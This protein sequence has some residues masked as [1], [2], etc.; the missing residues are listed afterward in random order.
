MDGVEHRYDPIVLEVIRT[1]VT[2]IVDEAA[3]VIVR[4]SFSMLLNEANDYSCVLTDDRGLLLAQNTASLPSFIG[5]LPNT[6]RH[7]IEAIGLA[8]M[9]PGDVLITNNPWKGSGHLNDVQ[10]VKPVFHENRLVAFAACCAHVPDIGGRIRSVEPREVFEEGFHIPPMK[11]L[12]EGVADE[13]LL[14]L[15][16]TNVRTPDQ[17]VGDLFAQV[18]ALEVM[19]HRLRTLMDD[20]GLHSLE[21]FADELYRR[22]DAAMREAV[23]SLPDGTYRYEMVTD[24]LEEPFTFRIALRIDGD[25]IDVDYAGTSPQQSRGI[26]VVYA[27]TFAMTAYALKCALLPDLPNNEGMFRALTVRAPEGSLLN[28]RFPASVGG[29]ICSGD[30]LPSLVF[31]A[32]HQV[33]PDRV[34]A[35]PGSPLWSMVVS[36]VRED[37][38]PY[39]NVLFYN[40]G[41]GATSRKDGVSCYSWPNNIASTPVEVTERDTPFFVRYKRLRENSG[42]E[43]RY[44][45]GLGQ[46]I[47]LESR[48]P[49]PMAAVFLAERTRMPAPGLAGGGAGGLGDVQINGRSIDVRRLH[50]LNEGDELLVRT[51]GAGG[52]GD[53]RERS[54]EA[55]ARDRREGW[56][57]ARVQEGTDRDAR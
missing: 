31:G 39:A 48:S 4:T 2:S 37:G 29:R 17:T 50:L 15:M 5:T 14:K 19:E 35:A 47:L 25:A 26:N 56:R 21:A 22:S 28:A 27:Y 38:K 49:T 36:G 43:G 34:A 9:R 33:I 12:R 13:S 8:A 57:D 20:Y 30:Y 1:R 24:G 6:V 51:P 45:G 53:V 41:M 55:L 10:L 7:F 3:K 18:G 23:R 11:L 44:C 32:L 52:Y 46:D 40:G 54:A 16:R 42:G